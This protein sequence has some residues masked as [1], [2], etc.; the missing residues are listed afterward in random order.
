M[1]SFDKAIPPGQ[2]GKL[3]FTIHTGNLR[4]NVRKT[5]RLTTNDPER[6]ERTLSVALRVIGSVD[7]LPRNRLVLTDG[8]ETPYE[9]TLV[10][11]KDGTEEGSLA[12]TDVKTSTPWLRA[13]VARVAEPGSVLAGKV[14]TQEGDWI[15]EAAVDGKLE[16]GNHRATVT[17]LTGLGREPK[18]TVHVT[19]VVRPAVRVTSN[20]L[21]LVRPLE[22]AE[23]RG[24]FQVVL[25]KGLDPAELVIEAEPDTLEIEHEV[26]GPRAVRVYVVL[27]NRGEE[28]PTSGEVRVRHGD[29]TRSVSVEVMSRN[30]VERRPTSTPRSGG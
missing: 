28:I 24:V 13:S 3:E 26:A 10:V 21:R 5:I 12:V 1:A 29:I 27:K 6:P 17:F 25:K 8:G 14:R 22:G 19:A 16:P 18:V 7:L 4:G 23:T 15:V 11:R 30:P 9:A 2:E 20:R